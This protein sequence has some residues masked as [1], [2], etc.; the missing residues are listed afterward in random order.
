MLEELHMAS[1]T[2]FPVPGECRGPHDEALRNSAAPTRGSEKRLQAGVELPNTFLAT[3][4]YATTVR[5][6]WAP[7]ER[8]KLGGAGD[9][10]LKT[11]NS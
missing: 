7:G 1:T 8:C 10:K 4:P 3:K 11:K 6:L 9:S 2:R 5:R